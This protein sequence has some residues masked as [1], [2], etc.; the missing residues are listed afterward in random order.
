[1]GGFIGLEFAGMFARFGAQVTI[2]NSAERLLP[3]E[4]PD[5]AASVAAS[6]ADAGIRVVDGVRAE[7][8][9]ESDATVTVRYDGG[10]LEAD[11]VLLA[12]GR[13]PATDGLGLAA[14]GIDADSRGFIVVDEHL[15][16]SAD[17]V[18]AVGDV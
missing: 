18:F 17:G 16:T 9:I 5:V 6:L 13:Q 3:G 4:D 2:L 12:T 14:A 7:E 11:A 8:F 1:G 15:R 10:S